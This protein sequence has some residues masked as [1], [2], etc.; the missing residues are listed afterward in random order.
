MNKKYNLYYSGEVSLELLYLQNIDLSTNL[1]Y[2]IVASVIH[3][4]GQI[5]HFHITSFYKRKVTDY[6]QV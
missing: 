3:N 6:E 2:E 4:L 5:F 1:S